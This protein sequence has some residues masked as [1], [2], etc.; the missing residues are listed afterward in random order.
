MANSQM[1]LLI[2]IR[3]QIIQICWASL[4]LF[5]YLFNVIFAARILLSD[6]LQIINVPSTERGNAC[7]FVVQKN[8]LAIEKAGQLEDFDM[9]YLFVSG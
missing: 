5:L 3:K 2:L 8:L 4:V 9:Q 1:S 7:D 6:G